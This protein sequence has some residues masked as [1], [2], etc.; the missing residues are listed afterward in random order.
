MFDRAVG[1]KNF[2]PKRYVQFFQMRQHLLPF[3]H[4]EECDQVVAWFDM[5]LL[6]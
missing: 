4:R 3:F 1:L 2:L 5:S 6:L